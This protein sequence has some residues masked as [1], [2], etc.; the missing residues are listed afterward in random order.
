MK[1]KVQ[2]KVPLSGIIYFMKK[3]ALLVTLCNL[4]SELIEL[5]ELQK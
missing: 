3:L 5:I 2:K 4:S 1:L